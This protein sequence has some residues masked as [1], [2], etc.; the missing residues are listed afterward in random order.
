MAGWGSHSKGINWQSRQTV[1]EPS[2]SINIIKLSNKLQRR[3]NRNRKERKKKCVRNKSRMNCSR[4]GKN[5]GR[6][7]SIDGRVHGWLDVF[8]KCLAPQWSFWHAPTGQWAMFMPPRTLRFRPDL[9]NAVRCLF[10]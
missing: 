6:E 4:C 2:P 10:V 3:Y 9:E 5:R 8:V 7:E 1:A